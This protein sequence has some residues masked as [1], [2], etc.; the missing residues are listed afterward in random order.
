[1]SESNLIRYTQNNMCADCNAPNPT[2]YNFNQGVFV[3]VYCA[4]VHRGLPTQGVRVKSVELDNWTESEIRE[5]ELSCNNEIVNGKLERFLPVYY[6]KQG[7]STPPD[8]RREFITHKYLRETFSTHASFL[9]YPPASGRMEGSLEKK[10]KDKSIWKPRHFVLSHLS[11]EYYLELGQSEPKSRVPLSQ[12]E[13]HLEEWER[14]RSCLVLTQLSGT[15]ASGRKYYVR[16]VSEGRDPDQLFDWYFALLTAINASYSISNSLSYVRIEESKNGNL[17][18]VGSHTFDCWKLRWFSLNGTHLTY[19]VNKLSAL[20]QGD[21]KIG[22]ASK[23]YR[24]EVGVSHRV[25]APSRFTFQIVTPDR[26]YKLCAESEEDRDSWMMVLNRI[27]H[28]QI[29]S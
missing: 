16:S 13:L 11:I 7:E 9:K 3:C 8:L 6:P 25:R 20:S 10:G 5:V 29:N 28:T 15:G 12:L 26:V 2:W 14:G 19:S 23:G 27:I 22:P 4:G 24:V 1:M 17:H 21:F 18:K